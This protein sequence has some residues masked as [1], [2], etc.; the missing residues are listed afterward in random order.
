M[1]PLKLQILLGAVD[2]ITAPLKAASGQSRT[3]AKD[4][5]ETRKRIKE[6]ETQSGQIDGY[7]TLGSQIGA[8][9]AQLTAAQRD[10]QQMAQQLAK[11]EQPTKAMTRAMEQA[12]QKV[13]DLSQ[14]EREMVARHGSL[15]R[16]MGEAGINTKQLGEHQRR[17]KTDLAS[18]N[19]QLDQQRA[20]L[21][22]LADQQK[23]LNQVKASYD[24]TMSM[25]G[26]MAGYGA[27]G[28]A[29]G[30]AAIYKGTNIAS[31]AMGFDVDMSKVQAITR[32]DKGSSELAALRAQARELGANTAFTAGEAAQGQ[33]FLA[34]AG[35][36]PKAIRDAMP[37]VLDIAKAGGVEIAAAADIGSN[38]LTGFKLPANQMTR[39][40]DVMVGTFT[41]AN[42]DLQMLG[43]TM[44]YV[45]PVAAGLGV[46]LETASAM[47]GKLGDAGI[48]GS[49][50]G[51]AMRA[52]L[53]R[54]AAPPKAA[55]DALA[56]LNVKT[57]DAAGNLRALPD[58]LDELYK[59]TSKMGDTTRSG[60]FK[61]IAGEE[62]FAALAV[63]TEQAGSGKLQELIATL[64][65]SQGEAGKVA[66]VMADNA[67]GDLDNL[68]SA[69]DDVGI[70]MME[71]ENGPMRGIIQRITEIIQVTGN[72]MRANPELTSTL[73]RIA[74]V[75]AVAAAAGGSLLLVVAGLLGP[76]AMLKFA[77]G[78]TLV[79]LG[80]LFLSANKTTE[81]L[82]MFSRMMALNSRMAAPLLARWAAL[83]NAIRGL[84]FAKIGAGM[85]A[86]LTTITSLPTKIGAMTAAT[87][88]YVSAQLATSKAAAAAKFASM[89]NGL[90]GAIAATYAY[91]AANGVMGTSLNL[92]KGSVGGVISLLKGSFVGALRLVGQTI[93]FVGR[94]LLMNPI[95]LLVTA[96]G[97]AALTIYRYWEPI[98][99]FFSGFFQ[100]LKEGLGPVAAV[101][102]PAFEA[103]ANALSPLKPIWDGISSALGS[104]WEWMTNLLTPIK[105]TQQELDGAT[106]AG[107]RF[108]LWLGGLGKS[109]IQVIADFTKFGSDLIDGLLKGISDKWAELKTKISA[110]TDLLPDWWKGGS[111]VK[112]S[113]SQSGYLTG[114]LSQPALVGGSGYGHR[115]ADTPKLKPKV[116]TTTIHS[117]PFY[118]LTV[119]PAPGMNEAQLGKLVMDKLKES[120]RANQAQGRA[121][122]GDRN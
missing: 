117:Q 67:I 119:N 109:F 38:I 89:I 100:G 37:G 75:T 27:A 115:I 45:G 98:K 93:A 59:K 24:K 56:A 7:R 72:W 83:G 61:A 77:L 70:Q 116:S 103:M 35:F 71:T 26:T 86:M 73:T 78:G 46:D 81:S 1:N 17:L 36:T 33:G 99:A 16:A 9:R 113:V 52:I 18:A 10:A 30:A 84:S 12:K 74:A 65:Q 8:T 47:A 3:T 28:M 111:E 60:Y 21:G 13:R 112:A 15:K 76:L 48:Q 50:G 29:T 80:G 42:V 63:L 121:R 101:F 120:E 94:L 22:Q 4:L 85:K 43:E 20:K 107:K 40:G 23:R 58:I 32:L 25:R 51:T 68:T 31:K 91:V 53:G 105:T 88:S 49:M 66:K 102:A 54:L 96:I 106:N 64:K 44:K 39:L 14:Q 97:I 2:K 108:G 62:A 104:A 95:G 55:H 114:N 82:S 92:L 87:W 41:R 122:F 57:A 11:V 6:L 110:M 79:R 69:W 90:R 19:A 118:Q 5:A 34:M